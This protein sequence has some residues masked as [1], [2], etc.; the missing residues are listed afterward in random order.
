M[1]FSNEIKEK[2]TLLNI[3]LIG[4]IPE[5]FNRTNEKFGKNKMENVI[6]KDNIKYNVITIREVGMLHY[7]NTI[8][9]LKGLVKFLKKVVIIYFQPENDGNDCDKKLIKALSQL[10]I[11][12]HPFIIFSTLENRNKEYY[13]N[14][15]NDSNIKFDH[16]N[17][18]SIKNFEY[19]KEQLFKI[20]EVIENYYN[21]E[22]NNIYINNDD[23]GINLCVIGKP[24]KGKSSF[25]NCI[26]E[27]KIALEGEG[28]NVTKNLINIKY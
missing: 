25:I 7:D 20:L 24:G 9:N 17:I 11:K 4:K 23:I 13:K 5:Y 12:Y 14:Y 3:I 6:I 19:P 8:D 1:G 21:E 26:A 22:E 18:Y 27:E 28:Q 2:T 10:E 15:I 16:L